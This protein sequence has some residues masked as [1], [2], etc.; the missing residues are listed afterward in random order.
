MNSKDINMNHHQI[1]V[2]HEG[3]GLYTVVRCARCGKQI[4]AKNKTQKQWENAN[5]KF[6]E[7]L[8][9]IKKRIKQ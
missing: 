2:Y 3:L 9:K 5:K 8:C 7:S 1:E 4:T 6:D